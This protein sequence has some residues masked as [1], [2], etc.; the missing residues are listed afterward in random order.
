MAGKKISEL[1]EVLSVDVENDYVVIARSGDNKKL[2]VANMMGSTNVGEDYV[3]LIGKDNKEYRLFV[4]EDGKAQ[5]FPKECVVGHVYAPGDNLLSPLKSNKVVVGSIDNKSAINQAGY[6]DGAGIVINQIFGGGANKETNVVQSTPISHS[7]VELY[8]CNPDVDVNLCGLYLH[9][10]GNKDSVWQTLALRGSVPPRCSFL[11]RGRR[12]ASMIMDMTL[13]KIHDYDQEWIGLDGQPIAFADN[14]MTMYLSTNA[15]PPSSA[16]I[17][18]L[19]QKD[20]DGTVT[21]EVI[22]Q[23]Y[24]D[25]LGVGGADGTQPFAYVGDYLWN[26]MNKDTAIRRVNFKNGT[27]EQFDTEPINYRKCNVEDVRPYS[28][29][30]GPWDQGRDKPKFKKFIPNL[31]N[32]TLG[33]QPNTRMFTWQTN[34]TFA[35]YLKYRKIMENNGTAVVKPWIEVETER[36]VVMNGSVNSEFVMIHRVKIT[37]LEPGVY[38]YQCGEPGFWSDVEKFRVKEY[39]DNST[40]KV[41]WTTDQQGFTD[42]EYKAWDACAK[43]IRSLRGAYDEYG[44]PNYDLHINT[45]DMSENAN[46]IWEW[47]DY[48]NYCGDL[49]K[50]LPHM[51]TCGN[52]DLIDQKYGYAFERYSTYEDQPMLN[53]VHGKTA[54]VDKPMVSTYSFDV[55]FIHFICINSNNEK[56]YSDYGV[57]QKEFLKKQ[58]Y[59]LDKDMWEVSQRPTKP[60]WVIVY[61]HLSPFTVT[62]ADRLQHWIPVIEHYGIDLFI[63]GHNHNY[64]RSIPIKCGYNGSNS[65]ADYNSYNKPAAGV[66]EP[67]NEYK[68]DGSTE[69]DRTS[70]PADGTYYVMFQSGGAKTIGRDRPL[71]LTDGAYT[72]LDSKHKSTVASERPWWYAWP[73]DRPLQSSFATITATKDSMRLSMNRVDGIFSEAESGVQTINPYN[74]ALTPT[75]FDSLTINYAERRPPYRTGVTAPYYNENKPN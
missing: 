72:G 14:G 32:M 47:L 71:I 70:H 34:A 54:T 51:T 68:A 9:Y 29:A 58:A 28:L 4:N 48:F 59:F 22:D 45:G 1:T 62:R 55:G 43:T 25:L 50:R 57:K 44:I 61:A 23:Y 7:F 18:V 3:D 11:I 69:I 37:D 30:D 53:D 64:S 73:H 10:R 33:K 74:P 42:A 31:L 39:D 8:N 67:V 63:C 6:I 56:M 17:A 21:G 41:L 46:Y 40:I 49:C 27:N 38:E 26:C 19:Q 35:G 36:E 2:K 16:P 12:H 60:K 52:N 13:C 24:V 15:T 75:E 5:L 66:Y 20:P 65:M